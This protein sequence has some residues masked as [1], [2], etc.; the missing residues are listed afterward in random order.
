MNKAL[1]ALIDS[2]LHAAGTVELGSANYTPI[3]PL[4]RS[5]PRGT[6]SAEIERDRTHRSKQRAGRSASSVS[7][8][9]KSPRS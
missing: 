8:R 9:Y 2:I 3:A 5:L 4:V 1:Q 6:Q 7:R